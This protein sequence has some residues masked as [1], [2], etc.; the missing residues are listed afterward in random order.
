MTINF[1]CCTITKLEERFK[2]TDLEII[3][4]KGGMYTLSQYTLSQIGNDSITSLIS[5]ELE[6][7]ERVIFAYLCGIKT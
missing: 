6:N 2:V 5:H 7:D 1:I 4:D 3:A